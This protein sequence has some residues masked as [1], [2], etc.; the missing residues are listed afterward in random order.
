MVCSRHL[1]TGEYLQQDNMSC[2]FFSNAPFL[3]AV[4]YPDSHTVLSMSCLA[5]LWWPATWNFFSSHLQVPSN[6]ADEFISFGGLK[7]ACAL[8]AAPQEFSIHKLHSLNYTFI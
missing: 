5:G 7:K 1:G 6:K 8:S 4:F 2:T 3:K